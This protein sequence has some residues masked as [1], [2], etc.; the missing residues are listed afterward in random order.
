[1]RAD[2]VGRRP[3]RGRT[4]ERRGGGGDAAPP[5]LVAGA[6]RLAAPQADRRGIDRFLSERSEA[7]AL[8]RGVP[9]ADFAAG[10]ERLQ[11][12]VGAAGQQH[13]A[14]DLAALVG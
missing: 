7:L 6:V 1:A 2:A 13:A 3:R 10:E 5:P 4:P 8:E 12:V 9:V 11:A 14:E